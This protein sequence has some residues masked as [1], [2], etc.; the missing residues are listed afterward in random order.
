MGNSNVSDGLQFFCD[1]TQEGKHLNYASV[2]RTPDSHIGDLF[3]LRFF[4]LI[5]NNLSK[6]TKIPYEPKE[7]NDNT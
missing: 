4:Y 7:A 3:L 5:F 6:N 1:W 2:R